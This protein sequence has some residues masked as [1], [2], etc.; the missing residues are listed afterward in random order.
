MPGLRANQGVW[1]FQHPTGSPRP[2]A[3]G[4]GKAAAVI[5]TAASDQTPPEVTIEPADNG[6]IVRHHQRSNKKDEGGRT[7]RR[8]AMTTDEALGHAKS[9]LGGG[10]AKSKKKSS[11]RGDG[12]P[13]EPESEVTLGGSGHHHSSARGRA[14]RRRPRTGGRR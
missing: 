8:L 2:C 5:D 12:A 14:R 7:I 3:A 13:A 6:F 11:H 4:S 10:S 1:R 9:A